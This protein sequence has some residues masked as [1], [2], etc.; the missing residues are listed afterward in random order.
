MSDKHLYPGIDLSLRQ[1]FTRGD[2]VIGAHPNSNSSSLQLQVREVAMMGLMDR[3]TDKPNWHEKVL[4]KDIVSKWRQ[5]AM[6]Q[7][8]DGLYPGP[9]PADRTRLISEK[10]FNYCVAE[11]RDKAKFFKK[12]G[13]IY[14]LDSKNTSTSFIIKTDVLVKADLHQKLKDSFDKLLEDQASNP[15]WHPWTSDM[16]QDIVHPSMYPFVYNRS[17]FIHQEV[18]GVNDAID[19]W[20]GK[21]QV[22]VQNLNESGRIDGQFQQ[23]SYSVVPPDYWSEKYQWLPSTLAFQEDGTVKFTSYINNLHPKRYPDI[24][25][26]I[27]ELIDTCIPAWDHALAGSGSFSRFDLPPEY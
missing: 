24:Y 8:E 14:T 15:D 11:L 16:V 1:M 9:A 5:E 20:S 26:T 7:P 22:P 13:L 12:S 27:E 21:G 19:K 4:D 18:V 3:L 23:S 6:A 25:Q 2:Y 17:H 10:A